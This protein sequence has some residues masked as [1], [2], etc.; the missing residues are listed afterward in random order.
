MSYLY[1]LE[2]VQRDKI[3]NNLYDVIDPVI[4]WDD[5]IAYYPYVVQA[6][7]AMRIDLI[8]YSIYGNFNYIDELLTMNN[9]LNPWSIK[10][11]DIIKFC[12]EDALIGLQLLAKTDQQR[13][14]TELVNPN[15]DTKKDPNRD[16]GTGLTPTI[17]PSNIKEVSINY[18]DKTMK[19][20]D[21][22]Q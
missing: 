6:E 2:T 9:I 5:T 4:I 12:E 16:E 14:V 22:L 21:R 3:M 1:T 15:K 8:C 17:R 18:D 13:V 10:E 11:G 7:E 19:I 20:M